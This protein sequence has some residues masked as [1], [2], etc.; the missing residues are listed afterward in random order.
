LQ[1]ATSA[2]LNAS[3]VIVI[4]VRDLLNDWKETLNFEP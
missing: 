4:D 3:R 1:S 2:P